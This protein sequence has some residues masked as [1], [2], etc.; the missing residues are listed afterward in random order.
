MMPVLVAFTST[1]LNS[2]HGSVVNAL[3]PSVVLATTQPSAPS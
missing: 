1:V 2:L 3:M